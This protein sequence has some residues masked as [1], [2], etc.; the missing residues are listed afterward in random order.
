M[1]SVSFH[2]PTGVVGDAVCTAEGQELHSF[3]S[4][5]LLFLFS[6]QLNWGSGKIRKCHLPE[7][8][9]KHTANKQSCFWEFRPQK[10]S[11]WPEWNEYLCFLWVPSTYP[12]VSCVSAAS[13]RS[14]SPRGNKNKTVAYPPKETGKLLCWQIKGVAWCWVLEAIFMLV[15]L[16]LDEKLNLLFPETWNIKCLISMTKE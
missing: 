6:S 3:F 11:P 9:P 7:W 16:F 4:Y 1:L 8:N 13:K 12:Q 5:Q 14:H 2:C 15:G 10:V